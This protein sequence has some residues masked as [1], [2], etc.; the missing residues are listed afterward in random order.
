MAAIGLTD[1]VRQTRLTIL[2]KFD[3]RG[4]FHLTKASYFSHEDPLVQETP[5]DI[6]T[7]L[8]LKLNY[9]IVMS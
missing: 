5:A 4:A 9:S 3:F 2:T 1:F 6:L 8:R 7:D